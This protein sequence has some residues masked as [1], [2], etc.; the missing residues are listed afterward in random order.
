[1]AGTIAYSAT[2]ILDACGNSFPIISVTGNSQSVIVNAP[3]N[4]TTQPASVA[5]CSG[6]SQSFLVVATGATLSYQWRLGVT[7]LTNVAPYSGVTTATLNISNVTGL[8][9]NS[10]NVV[11]TETSVTPNCPVTSSSAILT[12][13]PT[14]VIFDRTAA[15]CSGTAFSIPISNGLPSATTIVPAGT[16]YAWGAPIVTGGITGGSL[17][18]N[19]ATVS[20]TLTNPTNTVQ[21]ATYTVTPTSGAAGSC[22]GATFQVVVTV[23]PK[24]V[25]FNYTPADIC[26]GDTFVGL[27]NV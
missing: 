19:Q 14:P 7:N 3:P 25:I 21:T 23:N 13:N 4:I 6:S 18:T 26:S 2:I 5:Q 15:I 27:V 1:M 9:G 10:Y 8:N 22:I 24:P 12:V 11:V 16:T 20:Q 17:Q